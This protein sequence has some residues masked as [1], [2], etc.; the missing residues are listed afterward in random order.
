MMMSY[1][2]LGM[3]NSVG[4]SATLCHALE[5]LV[6]IICVWGKGGGRGGG[7]EDG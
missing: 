3:C 4:G 7:W 5:I 2:G 6:V 1:G